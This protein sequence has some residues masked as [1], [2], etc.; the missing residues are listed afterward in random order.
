MRW[1]LSWCGR[2]PLRPQV[3]VR[4]PR[5]GSDLPHSAPVMAD[6]MSGPNAPLSKAFIFCG[7][8][9]IS[10]DWLVGSSHDLSHPLRQSSLHQQL[11]TVDFLLAA[12]DCSTKSRAREIPIVFNDG[13]PGPKPLRSNQYPL[14][15][16][17][18]SGRDLERVTKDNDACHWVLQELLELAHRGGGSIRENPGNSLHWELPMEK[19]M[20]ASGLWQDFVYSA[21]CFMGARAKS[22]RGS[23]TTSRRSRT[24]KWPNATTCMTL[25]NGN[26]SKSTANGSI[27]R[28]RK[29]STQHHWHSP[30][31]WPHPSGRFA[32]VRPSFGSSG[33]P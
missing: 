16:P 32:L 33:C 12:L 25:T 31:P 2:L 26:L 18:L 8:Q 22:T 24:S 4:V 19:E 14:G 17:S 5:G 29:L 11:Q 30:L 21:C 20:M 28:R 23:D 7:W 1:Q 15:V 6:L 27:L 10:V 9:T 3:V 13:R